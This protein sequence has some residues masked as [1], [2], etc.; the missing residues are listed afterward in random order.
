VKIDTAETF[1]AGPLR[2]GELALDSVR[3][4][5]VQSFGSCSVLR[6]NCYIQ[7]RV[8][9]TNRPTIYGPGKVR[10]GTPGPRWF[11]SLSGFS[12]IPFGV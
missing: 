8:R 3:T 11:Y 7:G 12:Q 9:A 10:V 5:L 6:Y 1:S 4:L 2:V